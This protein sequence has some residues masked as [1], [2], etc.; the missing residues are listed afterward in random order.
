MKLKISYVMF[1][2]STA[3]P[4][5]IPSNSMAATVAQKMEPIKESIGEDNFTSPDYKKG[6]VQH[7]VLFRYK[8]SVTDKQITEI[9]ERFLALKDQ[10]RRNG[11]PYIVRLDAGSQNSGEGVDHGYQQGFIV[12]FSSEGDRNYYVGSPIVTD[13]GH[14]D[15]AHQQF[16]DFVGPFLA[17][18]NGVLVFD[19][20]VTE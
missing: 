14:Y 17:D 19:F 9:N 11:Q 18:E 16:K 3:I 12:I 15:P 8:D 1:V 20:S 2:L 10:A 4:Y 13:P 5:L 7:I 6:T